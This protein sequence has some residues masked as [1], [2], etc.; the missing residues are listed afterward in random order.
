MKRPAI[1]LTFLSLLSAQVLGK[2]IFPDC[3]NGPG[4]LTGNLVCNTSASPSERATAL[5]SAWNITEKL[6]NL[7]E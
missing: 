4:I 1:S 5:I 3:V 6:V 2:M 7:V